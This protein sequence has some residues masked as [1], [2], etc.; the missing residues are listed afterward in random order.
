MREAK[1]LQTFKPKDLKGH[2]RRA[3]PV[4][5]G[6]GGGVGVWNTERNENAQSGRGLKLRGIEQT[7]K[8]MVLPPQSGTTETLVAEE[9][10]YH[11]ARTL[12]PNI[13][14]L[15]GAYTV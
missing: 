7:R 5:K 3:T 9:N 11:S 4:W 6:G 1:E 14:R 8:G 15:Q 2:T 12:K 10:E 13:K